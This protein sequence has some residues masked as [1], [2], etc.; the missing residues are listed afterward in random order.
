MAN[1]VTKRDWIESYRFH[2][3]ILELRL[4]LIYDILVKRSGSATAD[5]YIR[6]LA[7]ATASDFYTLKKVILQYPEI[8]ELKLINKERYRQ[9]VLFMGLVWNESKGYIAEKYL[10]ISRS[11]FY[12]GASTYDYLSDYVNEAWL[13]VLEDEVVLCNDSATKLEVERFLINF[14]GFLQ[15]FR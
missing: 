11:T 6:S 10:R 13:A 1:K 7:E 2:P 12:T 14:N 9:E 8:K 15:D 4:I 3:R 5:V